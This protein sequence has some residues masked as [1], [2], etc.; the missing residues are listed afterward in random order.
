METVRA[1]Q[2]KSDLHL[3]GKG[4]EGSR[5]L[6]N[7][8]FPAAAPLLRCARAPPAAQRARLGRLRRGRLLARGP[9]QRWVGH[10]STGT[11]TLLHTTPAQCAARDRAPLQ[12]GLPWRQAQEGPRARGGDADRRLGPGP[13]PHRGE[14]C[15]PAPA[16][17]M[18]HAIR[19]GVFD[20]LS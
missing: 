10:A 16:R 8:L 14:Q 9:L 2:W 17:A 12:D 4:K 7:A 5:A 13:A 1:G 19:S 11:L 15:A 3:N 18:A 20:R 6:A